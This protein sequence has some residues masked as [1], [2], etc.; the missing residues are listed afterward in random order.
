SSWCSC[1]FPCSP[2]P[3]C[4][5]RGCWLA[6]RSSGCPR[7]ADA[8]VDLEVLVLAARGFVAGVV[9]DHA[10]HVHPRL[11]RGHGLVHDALQLGVVANLDVADQR[12]ILAERMADET[13]VGEDPAQVRVAVEHDAEHVEGLALEPV[14]HRPQVGD[15]ID[16][17]QRVVGREAGRAYAPVVAHRKQVHDHGEALARNRD[18]GHALRLRYLLAGHLAEAEAAGSLAGNAA[19]EA[20]RGNP[21]IP[22]VAA[23]T[24]AVHAAHVD[25]HL[26]AE[27][28]AQR[29][30]A[31]MPGGGIE[32][33]ADLAARLGH[34]DLRGRE[35]L[36]QA[37]REID[38]RG[39]QRNP[40]LLSPKLVARRIF[41][42]NCRVPYTRASEVGG[43]PGTYTSTGTALSQ[44]R[45]TAYE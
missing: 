38:D 36:A 43:Q 11:H 7:R 16:H 22:L 34:A 6:L 14:G 23:V 12:E 5:R 8:T 19:R 42:C 27:L 44:P 20:L 1:G 45:T 17:R 10:R 40:V 31:F 39:H 32:D 29:A 28:V 35:A 24:H 13:V 30:A 4:W 15:R 26:E 2:R 3:D 37:G 18:L 9:A 33:D 21:G 25:Q 41:F